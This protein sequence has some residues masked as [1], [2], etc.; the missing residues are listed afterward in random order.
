MNW[1]LN[2]NFNHWKLETIGNQIKTLPNCLTL[3]ILYIEVNKFYLLLIT[4]TYNYNYIFSVLTAF[5]VLKKL[6]FLLGNIFQLHFLS[7]NKGKFNWQA[8]T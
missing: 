7:R 5:S 8:S 4:V 6:D 1:Q 2:I 3:C